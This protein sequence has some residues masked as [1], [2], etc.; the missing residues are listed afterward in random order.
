MFLSD[1]VEIKS[2]SYH[3]CVCVCVCVCE[4]VCVCAKVLVTR[5]VGKGAA[6]SHGC[7]NILTKRDVSLFFYSLPKLRL[8][9]GGRNRAV[10]MT[11]AEIR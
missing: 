7:T 11:S 8:N 2:S 10:E 9:L 4:C 3:C 6:S 5:G 1:I